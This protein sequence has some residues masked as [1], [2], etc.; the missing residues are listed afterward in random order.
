MQLTVYD[1]MS[2]YASSHQQPFGLFFRTREHTW[3]N[4]E[5]KEV[6]G[7]SEEEKEAKPY[8]E[9][10]HC[11]QIQ[12]KLNRQV[13]CVEKYRDGDA[14]NSAIKTNMPVTRMVMAFTKFT[15]I[16]WRDFGLYCG[17][18]CVPIAI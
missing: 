4:T 1:L 17:V 3:L 9:L 18:G 11:K 16:L 14:A 13:T 6:K 2:I 8:H 5:S 15:S 12:R 10:E 7:A